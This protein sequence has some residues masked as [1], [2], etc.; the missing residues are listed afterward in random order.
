[1]TWKLISKKNTFVQKR[2]PVKAKNDRK[3][4]PVIELILCD[5]LLVQQGNQN[6]A[7]TAMEFPI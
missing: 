6:I 3:K 7:N 1:M 4:L 2:L 5:I